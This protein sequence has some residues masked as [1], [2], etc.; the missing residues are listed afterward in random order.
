MFI[1]TGENP[2]SGILPIGTAKTQVKNDLLMLNGSGV[3]VAFY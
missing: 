2:C 3:I 1:K